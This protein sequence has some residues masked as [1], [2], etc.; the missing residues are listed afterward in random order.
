VSVKPE[1]NLEIFEMFQK[2]FMKYFRAKNLMTFYITTYN[3]WLVAWHSGRTLVFDYRTF[4]VLCSTCSWRV[5]TY[6]GNLDGV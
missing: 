5:T 3:W 4:S 2:Y 1:K 6:M